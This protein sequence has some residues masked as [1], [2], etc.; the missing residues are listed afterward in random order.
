MVNQ[1]A[2]EDDKALSVPLPA[3]TQKGRQFGGK[4]DRGRVVG[5]AGGVKDNARFR[6]V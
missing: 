5:F 3:L 2:G 1:L 4:A 6:G